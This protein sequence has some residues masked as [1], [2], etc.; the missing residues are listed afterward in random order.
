MSC[1]FDLVLAPLLGVLE[2]Q[3]NL[4]AVDERLVAFAT[5]LVHWEVLHHPTHDVLPASRE[6][7]VLPG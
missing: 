6:D 2:G 3:A 7:Q 5:L 1:V 4:S